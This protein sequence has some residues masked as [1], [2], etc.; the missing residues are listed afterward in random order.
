MTTIK[1]LN[2]AYDAADEVTQRTMKAWNIIDNNIPSEA[3]KEAAQ[4]VK[5]IKD[6]EAPRP[7]S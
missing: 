4:R 2:K 6:R 7:G 3:A 1:S 5:I